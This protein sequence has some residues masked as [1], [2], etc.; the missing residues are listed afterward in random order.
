MNFFVSRMFVLLF[1]S[2]RNLAICTV[3]S[4]GNLVLL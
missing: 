4:V 1:Y 2:C 3:I